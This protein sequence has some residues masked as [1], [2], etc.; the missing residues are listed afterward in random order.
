[1]TTEDDLAELLSR[2]LARFG[3]RYKLTAGQLF[4]IIE[5]CKFG[6]LRKYYC[7]CDDDESEDRGSDTF[8]FSRN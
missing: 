3:E 8:P 4:G 5:L 6:M 1:M 2:K 7:R